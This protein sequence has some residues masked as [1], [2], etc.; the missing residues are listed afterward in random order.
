M[1]QFLQPL[2]IALGANTFIY[3]GIAF[4]NTQLLPS[5]LNGLY[6]QTSLWQRVLIMSVVTG[7]LANY[8]FSVVYRL[9][10][11]AN[12]GMMIIGTLALV[13]ISKAML[14]NHTMPTPRIGMAAVALI[15]AALWLAHELAQAGH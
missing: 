3:M 9:A 5:V 10:G 8:L 2:M 13:L 1:I 15:A 7:P 12:A 14:L 11:P 4:V 6:E